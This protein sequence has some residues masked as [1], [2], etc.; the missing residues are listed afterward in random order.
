[1]P[2]EIHELVTQ[3][4]VTDS[5]SV[6]SPEVLARIVESVLERLRR[7]EQAERARRSEHDLRPIVEQQRDARRRIGGGS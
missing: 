4:E 1:M 5:Q 7:D 6:L 2:V 3:V